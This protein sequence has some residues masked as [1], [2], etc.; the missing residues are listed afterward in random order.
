MK[1]AL[2]GEGWRQEADQWIYVEGTAGRWWGQDVLAKISFSDA[3]FEV[4]DKV[5][6]EDRNIHLKIVVGENL[7]SEFIPIR[8]AWL[9]S[10]VPLDV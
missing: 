1:A 2:L 5:V 9:S 6:S 7:D 4:N 8:K 3:K 10:F